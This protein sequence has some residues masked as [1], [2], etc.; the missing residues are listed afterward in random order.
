MRLRAANSEDEAFLWQAQYHAALLE[1]T[2]DP[3]AAVQSN[4]VLA[5]YVAGWGRIGDIGVIAEYENKPVGAAW[6]RLFQKE[7]PG[8][9]WIDEEIRWPFYQNSGKEG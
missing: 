1:S 4:P 3:A 7:T 2:G 5:R 9:G 6:C 8:W